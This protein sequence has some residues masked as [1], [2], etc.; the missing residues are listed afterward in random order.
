MVERGTLAQKN[1]FAGTFSL[2]YELVL[3]ELS[4]CLVHMR[5]AEIF[6]TLYYKDDLF[7]VSPWKI[8]TICIA[9]GRNYYYFQWLFDECVVECEGWEMGMVVAGRVKRKR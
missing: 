9:E 1:V 8:I 3:E 4:C 6:P 7:V 2:E 5:S